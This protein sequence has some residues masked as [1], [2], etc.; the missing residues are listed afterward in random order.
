[1]CILKLEAANIL[2][3]PFSGRIGGG[4]VATAITKDIKE[5]RV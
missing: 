5:K 3:S 1:M 2:A 4:S